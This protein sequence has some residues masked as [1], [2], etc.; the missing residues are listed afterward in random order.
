[1]VINLSL[2]M[3]HALVRASETRM[4]TIKK[5]TFEYCLLSQF[6]EEFL[7]ILNSEPYFDP[8]RIKEEVK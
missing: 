3:I 4:N 5:T 8:H 7:E 1:M 2:D 6:S